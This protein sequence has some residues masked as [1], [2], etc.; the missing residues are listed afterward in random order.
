M[1]SVDP[2]TVAA[3]GSTGPLAAGNS[4]LTS[5]SAL[6]TVVAT[7]YFSNSTIPNTLS[8]MADDI[9]YVL[10]KPN[11]QW[12][13]GVTVDPIGTVTRGW[14]PPSH[15]KPVVDDKSGTATPVNAD[16]SGFSSSSPG[17]SSGVQGGLTAL[18]D[19]PSSSR[20][21]SQSHS[22]N[23]ESGDLATQQP[24]PIYRSHSLHFV[25]AEEIGSY[26]QTPNPSVQPTFAFTPLWLPELTTDD[27]F[28][29]HNQALNVYSRDLPLLPAEEGYSSS[30]DAPSFE[31]PDTSKYAAGYYTVPMSLADSGSGLL[32]QQQ[33]QQQQLLQG[34][35]SS[36]NTAQPS[37]T[38]DLVSKEGRKY[39]NIA[40]CSLSDFY[41]AP[42]DITT[43]DALNTYFKQ[44]IDSALEALAKGDKKMFR[45]NLNFVSTTVATYQLIVRLLSEVLKSNDRSSEVSFLLKKLTSSL[46]QFIING[47]LHLMTS[48]DAIDPNGKFEDD[49]DDDADDESEAATIVQRSFVASLAPTARPSTTSYDSTASTGSASSLA[50]FNQAQ[51]DA[52]KMLRRS[53]LICD[54][55]LNVKNPYTDDTRVLPIIYARY[56]RDCF[57][58][59]NFSNQFLRSENDLQPEDGAKSNL[60]LDDDVVQKMS[61]DAEKIMRMLEKTTEILESPVPEKIPYPM[62]LEDR[63]IRILTAVYHSIPVIDRYLDTIESIDFT[64]FSMIAKLADKKSANEAAPTGVA[65]NESTTGSDDSSNFGA[66]EDDPNQSFYEATTRNL[67]P[68]L[69]EFVHLKQD[70]HSILSD[71]IL[72]CQLLTTDDPEVF[73]SFT[74]EVEELVESGKSDPRYRNL[75]AE[76]FA[77]GLVRVL[78]KRDATVFNG[79]V[80]LYEPSLKLKATLRGIPDKL[81]LMLLSVTQLRDQRQS[82]LNYCSRL[83]NSDFNIASLFVAERHNTMVSTMSQSEYYYG[84]KRSSESGEQLPWFLDMDNDE[85]KLIYD[86]NGLKGG[87]TR[88]LISKLVDPIR[89]NEPHFTETFLL[90]FRTFTSPEALLNILLEQLNLEMPEALSY[91]E[92]GV[93]VEQKQHPQQKKVL[94]V[95]E[96]L[97]REFWN[98]NYSTPVVV[99]RWEAWCRDPHVQDELA[100]LGRTV[101]GIKDQNEYAISFETADAI[102]VTQIVTPLPSVLTPEIK[103]M[104]LHNLDLDSVATQITILQ[105]EF[106]CRISRT[107]LIARSYNFNKIFRRSD[108]ISTRSIACFIKNCNQLTHFVIYMVLRQGEILERVV[109]IKFFVNLAEKL[110]ELKNFSSMTAIISGL[111]STSISRLKTT[112]SLLPKKTLSDFEKMDNL[113]SIG[114]NYSEYRNML[115][116]IADDGDP[117]LP[118]LGM[119]LSDLRFTTDGNS[120]YIHGDKNLVNF[121][122]RSAICRIVNEVMQFT[123]RRYELKRDDNIIGYMLVMFGNLPDDETL[124]EMSLKWEPRVSLLTEE[125]D[126]HHGRRAKGSR[127]SAGS[128]VFSRVTH[129]AKK[130]NST[131]SQGNKMARKRYSTRA[132]YGI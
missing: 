29:F 47:N 9:V 75:K 65:D 64:L 96:R 123:D 7:E 24:T 20:Q 49:D 2:S 91:E 15:T 32:Q 69:D 51:K 127:T 31:L 42:T 60:L 33:Q 92:Y 3:G 67:R 121:S 82:I 109:T 102:H 68:I 40:H 25:S 38:V 76:V 95:V 12:W 94:T 111:G 71:L 1:S 50:Y 104:R 130:M 81:S 28:I 16:P 17:L 99:Q 125:Q 115:K 72:D 26:F 56:I 14:F 119:Y 128:S 61:H 73:R 74:T 120:N 6:E 118:F 112:W 77:R 37:V 79:G 10:S 39:D 44:C 62:F 21:Q 19:S 84:R 87:P 114:K 131:S 48:S 86:S 22:F 88:A 53:L 110:L 106:F 27:E 58:A 4:N 105:E 129:A 124:Y 126:G 80:Y 8:L 101:L 36:E 43:W 57:A 89:E 11:S 113:M 85:K 90:M 108:A 117:C 132:A 41:L 93:W 18:L 5:L 97:F 103:R 98:V 63:N 70:L 83:M 34:S 66:P 59:G 107:E 35:S 13:D 54:V 30:A 78:R 116:F 55:F 45:N 122:K 46:V 23:S 52:S 100:E